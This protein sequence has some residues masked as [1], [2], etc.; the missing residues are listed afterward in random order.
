MKKYA[1]PILLFAALIYLLPMAS[2][3]MPA[4]SAAS[5]R[6]PDPLSAADGAPETSLAPGQAAG[7]TE[8]DGPLLIL[9]ESSGKV[10]SVPMADYVL[11][12]VASEMPMSYPDE[13]LRAQAI[14]A[15]SYALAVKARADGSDAS[16][17]GAYFK[18]NPA[19]RLGYVTDDV[20]RILWGKDYA[21]NRARLEQVLQPV[22]DSVLLYAGQP[23]L[24]C[25][26]A[27]SSGKTESSEALWGT[28]LPYLVSVDSPLDRTSPGYEQTVTLTVQEMYECLLP[29]F[30]GIDLSGDPSGWFGPSEQDAAGYVQKI[31]VGGALCRG[32]DVRG[33]LGLCSA[34]FTVVYTPQ[35]VFAV[36]TRGYG[37]GVGLSQYGASAMAL[38]GKS[39]AEILAY[40]YPGTQLG[41]A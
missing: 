33:A 12:A 24:A 6:A 5:A 9:D 16:L 30:A 10:V 14:A 19:R 3:L 18:A 11:G 38:T 29:N 35:K 28:A 21:A 20:M 7:G 4:Q 40:Y 8:Q 27:I 32:A 26:H 2:L 31:R 41:T 23:A 36:T 22:M 39:C 17:K 13:A 34:A 37:H 25:Y 15:H 1:L